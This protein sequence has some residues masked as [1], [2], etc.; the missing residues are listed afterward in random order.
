MQQKVSVSH[1]PCFLTGI[2]SIKTSLSMF[3]L[4]MFS[5]FTPIPPP[6]LFSQDPHIRQVSISIHLC[7][8]HRGFFSHDV[9]IIQWF[10]ICKRVTH[11]CVFFHWS[12]LPVSSMAER[13]WL[14][15]TTGPI[16]SNITS[17]NNNI[18]SCDQWPST[19][20]NLQRIVWEL[21]SKSGILL[22]NAVECSM[23]RYAS[24]KHRMYRWKW[25][26]AWLGFLALA[27]GRQSCLSIL[28]CNFC[29]ILFYCLPILLK[30]PCFGQVDRGLRVKV[31]EH[32][33]VRS[34]TWDTNP[35]C[36]RY[37]MY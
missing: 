3:L 26:Q 33:S 29:N 7:K 24:I 10:P 13:V 28:P 14:Y 18:W 23:L 1:L 37:M 20:K 17:I 31:K 21:C 22:W 19:C 2:Q 32:W 12:F 4:S 25:A 9:M 11:E 16:L 15:F 8:R 34:F 27:K 30:S 6:I 35:H 5:M 36:P